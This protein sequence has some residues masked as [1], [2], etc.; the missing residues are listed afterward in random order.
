MQSPPNRSLVEHLSTIKDPR[1]NR[2]K[3]HALTDILVI[4]ICALLCRA[5]TFN[6]MEDFA[7]APR[8]KW[9]SIRMMNIPVRNEVKQQCTWVN[10]LCKCVVHALSPVGI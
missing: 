6:G 1:V 7:P 8:R 3:E 2:T 5:E 9:H 10:A 4:A